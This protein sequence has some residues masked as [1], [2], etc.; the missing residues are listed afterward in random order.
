MVTAAKTRDTA[1]RGRELRNF[2]LTVGIAFALLGLLLLWRGKT[3]YPY[4]LAASAALVSL[5]LA[6]PLLLA[7]FHKAWMALS[8]ILGWVM[9]RLVLSILFYLAFTPIGIIGRLAGR[10][11]L[12]SEI[13]RSRETYWVYR[14][15]AES[16]K[17]DCERQ[18]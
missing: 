10:K 14:D 15:A 7:P 5:G 2:G 1:A 3:F 17:P 4:F 6:L 13:D 12:D 9:T 11:F 16:A 18:F 8:A